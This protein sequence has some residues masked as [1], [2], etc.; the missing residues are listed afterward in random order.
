MLEARKLAT[1]CNPFHSFRQ[2]TQPV[3]AD[4]G[5][6]RMLLRAALARCCSVSRLVAVL[7]VLVLLVAVIFQGS[8][9]DFYLIQHN[10]GSVAWYFWFLADFLV[11]IGI[12]SAVFLARRHFRR[13]AQS[14]DQPDDATPEPEPPHQVLGR[15]PLCYLSWLLYALLLVAKVVLLF[16]MDVAQKLQDDNVYG[17]QFLKAVLAVAAVVFLLLVESHNEA[18]ASSEQRTY[19]QSLCTGT[20][21]EV[22]DSITFLGLLFP[23]ETHLTL[24]YPLENAVLALTCVNFLLPTL[25]LFK[26]SQ[27]EFG[28]LPRPLGLKLLYKVLHM[29]LVNVPY[30]AIR[31]YLWSFFGHDVSLF[32]IKNLLGIYS[33]LRTLVPELRLYIFLLANRRRSHTCIAAD[34]IELKVICEKDD[35]HCDDDGAPSPSVGNVL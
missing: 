34:P 31:I 10:Q 12:M 17:S 20:T 14:P 13:S 21:F 32:L 16:R 26:L 2:L 35:R 7:D 28:Q 18:G 25:A 6:V 24:T 19:L 8:T 33:A 4:S 30:L 1:R 29:G 3:S 23:N 15:F 27:C 9:L 22:L 11:L 5:G